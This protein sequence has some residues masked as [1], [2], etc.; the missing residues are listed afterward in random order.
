MSRGNLDGAYFAFSAPPGAS[1]S[2]AGF[3]AQRGRTSVEVQITIKSDTSECYPYWAPEG[4]SA[5]CSKPPYEFTFFLGPVV[6][7]DPK[8]LGH[9][10]VAE[11]GY[12]HWIPLD[13]LVFVNIALGDSETGY[14]GVGLDSL[15]IPR[16]FRAINVREPFRMMDTVALIYPCESSVIDRSTSVLFRPTVSGRFV[17]TIFL[18]DPLTN[19]SI[20]LILIGNAYVAGV[21]NVAAPQFRMFPNPCDRQLNIWLSGEEASAVEIWNVMGEKVYTSHA[22]NSELAVDCSLL[23]AG[24]YIAEVRM[25]DR[26]YRQQLIVAH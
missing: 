5:T 18:L 14:F 16:S 11:H 26:S 12:P 6:F 24:V 20:P 10:R 17:D 13:T 15:C 9:G 25:R 4:I 8:I 7:Y 1:V 21:E 23:P 2:P 22:V 19:D 3:Y